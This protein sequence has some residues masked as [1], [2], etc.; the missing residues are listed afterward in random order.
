MQVGKR[1]N[2]FLPGKMGNG[3]AAPGAEKKK[4]K[5]LSWT[6]E[7]GRPEGKPCPGLRKQE[8]RG[9]KPIFLVFFPFIFESSHGRNTYTANTCAYSENRNFE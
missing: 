3:Q 1:I 8:K 7:R 6:C 4:C 5:M 2:S 9:E